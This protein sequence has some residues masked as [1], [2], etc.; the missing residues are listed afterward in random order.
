MNSLNPKVSIVLTYYKKRSYILKTIN[1]ILKQTYKNFEL[2]FVYDD[3]DKTDLKY[4]KMILKKLKKKKIIINNRNLGVSKSRNK[5]LKFCNGIFI[6]FIDADDI[7]KKKKLGFQ[8][9]Y[10]LKNNL[11]FTCTSYDVI[12]DK[13]KVIRSRNVPKKVKYND[14]IKS[15]FIGLSTVIYK[16]NIHSKIK[17]PNLNTQEDFSLWL[18]LLRQGIKLNTISKNLSSWRKTQKSLS[19]NIFQKLKDSFKLFYRYENKN[20]I[21]SIFSVMVISYNKVL[22]D[23]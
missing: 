2:I 22:K 10:M 1:S 20:F 5:A 16:R 19:S 6:A 11:D 8:I 12:D 14:L 17:F 4:I 21:L 15:N 3:D 18:S 7:W 9:K 13:G 23:I